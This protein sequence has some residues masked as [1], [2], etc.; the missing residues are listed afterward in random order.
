MTILRTLATADRL[1]ARERGASCHELAQATGCCVEFARDL[2]SR[3]RR[4]G[5][6]VERIGSSHARRGFIYRLADGPL[7]ADHA[8]RALGEVAK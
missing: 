1:L 2:V 3:L 8:R 6:R 7:L 5:V 4:A